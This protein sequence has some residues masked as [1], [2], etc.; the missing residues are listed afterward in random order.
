ML[1][2][3]HCQCCQRPTQDMGD[4]DAGSDGGYSDD[5]DMSWKVAV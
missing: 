1:L 5:D 2:G 4:D 3:I